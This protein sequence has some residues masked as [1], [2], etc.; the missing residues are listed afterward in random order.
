M[1]KWCLRV[2]KTSRSVAQVGNCRKII[3]IKN[4]FVGI[5]QRQKTLK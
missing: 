2:P 5:F 3:E 4:I 1:M